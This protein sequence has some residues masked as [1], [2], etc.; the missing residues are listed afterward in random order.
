[1]LAYRALALMPICA[2]YAS[3]QQNATKPFLVRSAEECLCH[4]LHTSCTPLLRQQ[5]KSGKSMPAGAFLSSPSLK[6]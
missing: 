1:V 3:C 5:E 6:A 2:W 4:S